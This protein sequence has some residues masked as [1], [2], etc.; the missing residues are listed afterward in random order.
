[1][2]S[3]A[4]CIA[5]AKLDARFGTHVFLHEGCLEGS[6]VSAY[7]IISINLNKDKIGLDWSSEWRVSATNG[8]KAGS[9]LKQTNSS[10][11]YI[12]VKAAEEK[13]KPEGKSVTV[14]GQVLTLGD[15][16]RT[17]D[18]GPEAW[19]EMSIG[20]ELEATIPAGWRLATRDEASAVAKLG[21]T[22][23]THVLLH[24]GCILGGE[25]AYPII[26]KTLKPDKIGEN[27]SSKWPVT[28]TNGAQ[29]GSVLRVSNSSGRYLLVRQP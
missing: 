10:G 8:G 9:V 17:C 21:A 25:E 26:V 2:A 4:E 27:W 6:G 24:Q 23:G 7:P 11:R 3:R 14:G 12:L 13:G 15:N 29:P 1:L 20:K 16:L 22:F 18:L 28:A 5:I 19:A